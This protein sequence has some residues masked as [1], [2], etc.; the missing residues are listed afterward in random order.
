MLRNSAAQKRNVFRDFPAQ[1]ELY[2]Q[3]WKATA[4]NEKQQTDAPISHNQEMPVGSGRGSNL[5][6]F[7]KYDGDCIL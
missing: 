7:C 4:P 3:L 2:F 1:L 6:V 5:V